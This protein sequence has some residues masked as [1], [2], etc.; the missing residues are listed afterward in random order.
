MKMTVRAV[1]FLVAA[2]VASV[3]SAQTA[4]EGC[5]FETVAASAGDDPVS[6]GITGTVWL[7]CGTRQLNIAVQHEQGW[8]LYGKEFKVG[9]VRGVFAGFIG[10]FQGAPQGGLYLTLDAP[11]G[12]IAGQ[13]VAVGTLQ[14]PGA[15]LWEPKG[16]K[17]DGIP[18][19]ERLNSAFLS[20]FS[21]S[22]GPIGLEYSWLNFLDEPWNRIPGVSYTQK[23]RK[24]FSVRVSMGYNTNGGKWLPCIRA[25]WSPG[26]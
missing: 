15:F 1:L 23:V 22:I 14:W 26:S 20:N 6:S 3:A 19:P 17:E 25:T 18:N 8:I 7:K 24:D 10:H 11:L 4:Q 21:L 16:S 12:K 2:L 9:K 5:Q 13:E